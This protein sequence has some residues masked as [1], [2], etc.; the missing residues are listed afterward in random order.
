MKTFSRTGALAACLVLSAGLLTACGGKSDKAADGPAATT[1]I[2]E[3]DVDPTPSP[4]EPTTPTRSANGYLDAKAG[5]AELAALLE[6]SGI[7]QIH[8]VEIE[9]HNVQVVGLD[10]SGNA[11]SISSGDVAQPENLDEY[12][13]REVFAPELFDAAAWINKLGDV[14]QCGSFAAVRAL[15][16]VYDFSTVETECV[17]DE[18]PK[19]YFMSDGL[20]W[21]DIE[22][23]T[24][25]GLTAQLERGKGHGAPEK[26]KDFMIMVSSEDAVDDGAL[27]VAWFYPDGEEGQREL[28]HRV[29]VTKALGPDE[30][31]VVIDGVDTSKA[32]TYYT[33]WFDS[34][35]LDAQKIISCRTK[36]YGEE[37]PKAWYMRVV[38]TEKGTDPE[39]TYVDWGEGLPNTD[40]D[41]NE[42]NIF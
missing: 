41:C 30:R 35:E 38:S 7:K 27:R 8:T 40:F 3:P 25:E 13:K 24:V 32:S 4:E 18:D 12:E 31:G 1:T 6:K 28:M 19:I 42:I 39:F 15:G 2:S 33:T 20:A 16:S 29:D 37:N 23:Q 17:T 5:P 11:I 22:V 34:S 26:L 36:I 21:E 10:G 14:S 9:S